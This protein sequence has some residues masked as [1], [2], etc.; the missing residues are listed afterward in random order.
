MVNVGSRIPFNLHNQVIPP[1]VN[2]TL[3]RTASGT[4]QYFDAT[5]E[6]G[7]GMFY[8]YPQP[9]P[10]ALYPRFTT[11]SSPDSYDQLPHSARCIDEQDPNAKTI[12]N[13][14]LVGFVDRRGRTARSSS[15]PR[16]DLGT[17]NTPTL[18]NIKQL[19]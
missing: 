6:Y 11:S 18:S 8:P 4:L 12:L 9:Y 16:L 5:D 17:D 2:H 14:K 3:S 19:S 1:E 7:P 13:V 15:E 10:P